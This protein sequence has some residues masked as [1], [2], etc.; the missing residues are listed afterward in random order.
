MTCP[1]QAPHFNQRLTPEQFRGWC[2]RARSAACKD[3]GCEHFGEVTKKVEVE[4]VKPEQWRL[5]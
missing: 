5:F 3:K 4:K 1:L 2:E